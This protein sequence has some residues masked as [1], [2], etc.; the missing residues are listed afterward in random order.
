[1]VWTVLSVVVASFASSFAI[2][3]VIFFIKSQNKH[4][5]TVGK[6]TVM[7]YAGSGRFPDI[8]IY[9]KQF[10]IKYY[11]NQEKQARH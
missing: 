1:M 10:K 5:S 2:T 9:A 4:V 7:Q 11:Q 3:R 8:S 6:C